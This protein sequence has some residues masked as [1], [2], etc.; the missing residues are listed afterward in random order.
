MAVVLQ[1]EEREHALEMQRRLA[2]EESR[3]AAEQEAVRL[4]LLAAMMMR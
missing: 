2:E 4:S 3:K 1:E